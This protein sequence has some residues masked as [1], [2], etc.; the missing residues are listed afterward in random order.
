MKVLEVKNID[1]FFGKKQILKDIS[2][3][4]EEGEILGFVGPNGSGKTTTIKIILGLQQAS[5]GEVFINGNN[6]K[7]NYENAIRKVGA[8]VE[9]PDMYM[10]LSG[11]ENLKLVANYYNI[12]HNEIERVVEFV[13]LKDRI[14]DKVSKYSLGMRQRLGIAQAILNK[15]NL[16]IVDEPTNGLD[17]SGII[18]FRN[19]LKELAKKEKMSIFI[20]SHNLAEIENICDKVLLLKEG[21]IVS[22]DVL[23]EV[24][25]NDKY[26]LELSST[27]K[28]KKEEKVEIID[29][30]YIYYLGNKE[31]I[32]KFIETLV[33]K[34]I[35]IYSVVKCKES[36]EDIFIK[37]TGGK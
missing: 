4:I 1:K 28:L 22:S 32:A 15:P 7:D 31:D 5:R 10:Y 30:N 17:P 18:E 3:D 11:L 37:K 16:L 23:K 36:L 13:G 2:F 27:L 26:K 19:M 14:K 29:D 24:E 33:N 8:I 25:N 6:I 9:S 34:K 35:K 20:S 21:K 12:S